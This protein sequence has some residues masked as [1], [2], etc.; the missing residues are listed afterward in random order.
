MKKR[1]SLLFIIFTLFFSFQIA[2]ADCRGCCSR[3]GGVI[4]KN[5]VTM[6]AD[7]T[8]LSGKCVSKGCTK[9]FNSVSPKQ[10]KSSSSLQSKR[11]YTPPSENDSSSIKKCICDGKRIYT[12]G[13]CPCDQEEESEVIENNKPALVKGNTKIQSF[14]KA[15]KILL[16]QIYHDHKVTFYCGCPFTAKKQVEPCDNYKPKK[17]GKRAKRIEWEHVV[18]AAHFGQSFKEWREGNSECVNKKGKSF[19][20]RKCAEK[21]N[22]DYRYMQSDMYNL[23]PAI[24]EINGLRSNYRFGMI[25][26]EQR[27]FGACNMEISG[28]VAEPPE[29]IRGEIARTYIYMAW[30]YGR[31]IISKANKKLIQAWSNQDPVDAWECER[32]RRIEAIQGNENPIVK[33]ACKKA[34]M[35]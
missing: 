21:M 18:P 22:M 27:D 9:C 29:Q 23:Y 4:C 17:T 13:I 28:K 5:G 35:W 30:A 8:P 3:H 26:D 10:N 15:K 25:A 14:N 31:G 2:Y 33:K 1:L 19:K 32:C 20:G 24:G 12:D 11:K 34:G 16:R 6:C 7:G